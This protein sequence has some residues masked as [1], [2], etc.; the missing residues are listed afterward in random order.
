MK[1]IK[2]FLVIL[3]TTLICI[4]SCNVSSKNPEDIKGWWSAW[5][6]ST[7]ELLSE[8]LV[9]E[10]N[11]LGILII[12]GTNGNDW[13]K[14][15]TYKVKGGFLHIDL[16]GEDLRYHINDDGT[17]WSNDGMVILSKDPNYRVPFHFIDTANVKQ[18][19][20]VKELENSNLWRVEGLNF[21]MYYYFG[22][23]GVGDIS[24]NSAD[25]KTVKPVTEFYWKEIGDLIMISIG[26]TIEYY[27]VFN[28]NTL[29]SVEGLRKLKRVN[30]SD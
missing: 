12:T 4:C 6:K 19:S 29:V 25:N 30:I 11:N 14:K 18:I 13:E 8:A 21:D 23:E 3:I 28:T 1:T 22:E 2:L 10:E 27:L 5:N 16:D 7:G 9:L 15:F 17:I 24:A 20:Q 26:S